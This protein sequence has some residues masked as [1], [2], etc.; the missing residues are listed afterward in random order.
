[1]DKIIAIVMMI[2]LYV[3][4]YRLFFKSPDEEI[5]RLISDNDNLREIIKELKC[6]R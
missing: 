3:I 5:K 6:Q 4:V 2:P 1:M